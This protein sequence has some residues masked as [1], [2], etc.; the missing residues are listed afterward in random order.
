MI[1]TID[2]DPADKYG[3]ADMVDPDRI[4][5]ALRTNRYVHGLRHSTV[6]RRWLLT[7]DGRVYYD[8]ATEPYTEADFNADVRAG[9]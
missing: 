7:I 6:L 2:A 4:Q 1:V 5:V 8:S 9:A 3:P